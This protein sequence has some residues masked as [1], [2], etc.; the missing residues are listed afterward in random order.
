MIIKPP[1]IVNY[2]QGVARRRWGGRGNKTH[3]D[4]DDS[5]SPSTL[6]ANQAF[7]GDHQEQLL[8]YKQVEI[9]LQVI[10]SSH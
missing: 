1:F 3:G 5:S 6:N 2:A 8:G 4:G 10:S 9:S 7:G